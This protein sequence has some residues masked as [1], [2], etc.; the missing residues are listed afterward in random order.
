MAGIGLIA[1]DLK[2]LGTLCAWEQGDL[3]YCAGGVID[4][5]E[6]VPTQRR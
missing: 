1:G 6:L 2:Q 3:V 5:D 4:R